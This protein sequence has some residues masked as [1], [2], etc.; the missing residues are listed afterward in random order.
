MAN[1]CIYNWVQGPNIHSKYDSHYLKHTNTLAKV[2]Y[3]KQSSL[4]YSQG[5][6]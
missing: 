2:L 5:C 4:I 3:G 6:L 1:G